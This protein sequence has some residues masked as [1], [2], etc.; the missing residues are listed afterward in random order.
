MAKP[1]NLM[2]GW[3]T[4]DITPQG[5]VAL[6]GQFDD[7][8]SE[9]VRDPLTA[10]A[11]A[12]ESLDENG[13]SISGFVMVSCDLCEIPASLQDNVKK[14]VIKRLPELNDQ[15]VILSAT[16]IH[17]GPYI[18][19]SLFENFNDYAFGWPDNNENVTTPEEYSAFIVDK[20]CDAVISAWDNRCKGAVSW[21]LGYA[22]IGHNRRSVYDDATALMYGSTDTVKYRGPEGPSDNGIELIYFWN[23]RNELTGIAVNVSCPAQIVEHKSYISADYWGELRKKVCEEFG[24]EIC[25]LALCG[26][27]GDQSPRDLVRRGRGDKDMYSEEGMLEIAERLF[28]VIKCKMKD[29]MRNIMVDPVLKHSSKE[30]LLPHR[31]ITKAEYEKEKIR[32]DDLIKKYEL[33]VK[34]IDKTRIDSQELVEIYETQGVLE[35]YEYYKKNPA[36]KAELHFI[37]IGDIAIATNPFELYTVY[38]FMIKARSVAVQTLLAQLSCDVGGYLATEN[39]INNGHYS[40]TISSGFVG[41][42]G[43]QMLVDYS[44]CCIN[45]LWEEKS[46]E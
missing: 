1:E 3:A 46:Y 4:T 19:R 36:Y 25:V 30:L 37:R 26:A 38:G 8:F 24:N 7:R 5:Q 31:I 29:A 35:R 20:I 17:T 18:T 9:H 10:T 12:M 22:V 23:E 6:L 34:P 11:L 21:Q 40:T 16:H 28:T 41:P 39:A 2:V 13:L 33:N 42:D 43:G 45:E 27:A 32:F 14:A 15:S 44:V